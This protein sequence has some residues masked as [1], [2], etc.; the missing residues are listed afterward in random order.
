MN[1]VI[2]ILDKPL[3]NAYVR[4]TLLY[5]LFGYLILLVLTYCLFKLFPHVRVL[6][7]F[8][9]LTWLLVSIQT[10]LFLASF[11]QAYIPVFAI[12]VVS[13]IVYFVIM[14]CY[15]MSIIDKIE[16]LDWQLQNSR[17]YTPMVLLLCAAAFLFFVIKLF[18]LSG[19]VALIAI[20]MMNIAYSPI[21][22]YFFHQVFPTYQKQIER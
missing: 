2:A 10:S 4:T 16:G 13:T 21:G 6:H 11:W 19:Y 9:G 14:V 8:P 5:C 20:E 3:Y 18:D 15:Q 1:V 22:I 7:I 12:F 17:L